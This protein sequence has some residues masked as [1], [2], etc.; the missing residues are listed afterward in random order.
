M[1]YFLTAGEKHMLLLLLFYRSTRLIVFKVLPA[2][3][4][5]RLVLLNAD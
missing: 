4:I 5:I 3:Q 1:F 2:E